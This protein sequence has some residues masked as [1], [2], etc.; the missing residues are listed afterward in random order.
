MKKVNIWYAI[1]T[2]LLKI[3]CL[4][5]YFAMETGLVQVGNIIEIW[6]T[7]DYDYESYFT[8]D[9]LWI[10]IKHFRLNDAF[11]K[12]SRDVRHRTGDY[13]EAS[14]LIIYLK[15][16]SKLPIYFIS[17]IY[18]PKNTCQ[19]MCDASSCNITYEISVKL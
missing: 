3:V 13:S 17:S 2:I 19:W 1:R 9:V 16:Y 8:E 15:M 18:P 14:N 5:M 7:P 12:Q 11:L 6:D 10:S 4:S